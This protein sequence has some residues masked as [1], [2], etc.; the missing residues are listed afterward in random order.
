MTTLDELEYADDSAGAAYHNAVYE[1]T[2]V[3]L[4]DDERKAAEVAIVEARAVYRVAARELAAY[5][6]DHYDGPRDNPWIYWRVTLSS[7]RGSFADEGPNPFGRG[8]R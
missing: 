5:V 4:T 3:D 6:D 2:R 8:H 7:A 1:L